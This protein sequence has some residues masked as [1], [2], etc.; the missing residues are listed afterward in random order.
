MA[1]REAVILS[2][3]LEGL[4]QAETARRFGVSESF[5]SRLLA[6]YRTEGDTA[7]EPRSRRPLT[8]PTAAGAT[9]VELIVNLRVQLTG[10]G[11]DLRGWATMR[12]ASSPNTPFLA[13]GDLRSIERPEPLDVGLAAP[14]TGGDGAG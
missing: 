10:K 1:K 13:P 9:M 5:V 2:V 6:R 12:P 7:F 4:S 11:L 14:R 8:S 3:T